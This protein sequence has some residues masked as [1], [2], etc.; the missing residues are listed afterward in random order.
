[1][2][3]RIGPTRHTIIRLVNRRGVRVVEGARLESVCRGNLTVGSN[4]T[5]SASRSFLTKD[6]T[7]INRTDLVDSF[8]QIPAAIPNDQLRAQINN[9][10]ID[11]L[12]K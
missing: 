5:L 10:F 8:E 6:D 4:P 7:W 11:L 1:M 12:P 3:L 9:Y 2:L